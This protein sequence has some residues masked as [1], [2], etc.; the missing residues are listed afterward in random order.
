MSN[1]L[2]F[3]IQTFEALQKFN[4]LV[5]T[6]ATEAELKFSD[7][8]DEAD[9]KVRELYYLPALTLT[10]N[11]YNIGKATVTDC[12]HT[13]R[14]IRKNTGKEVYFYHKSDLTLFDFLDSEIIRIMEPK[15]ADLI[16]Y[17]DNFCAPYLINSS[18]LKTA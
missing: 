2:K 11:G 15:V 7:V 12:I 16:K 17:Y 9:M 13:A 6:D 3:T 10:G 5:N 1:L 14:M 18:N 8:W 4:H